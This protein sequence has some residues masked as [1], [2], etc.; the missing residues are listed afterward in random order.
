MARHG[1]ALGFLQNNGLNFLNSMTFDRLNVHER[2]SLA[3][4]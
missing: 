1:G 2:K 3:E 4:K